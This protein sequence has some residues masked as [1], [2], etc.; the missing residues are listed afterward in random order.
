MNAT[1]KFD[2]LTLEQLGLLPKFNDI[3]DH[4]LNGPPGILVFSGAAGSGKDTVLQAT[5]YEAYQR[6]YPIRVIGDFRSFW[7]LPEEW[8]Q[9][10]CAYDLE[11]WQSAIGKIPVTRRH[12]ILVDQFNYFS[13]KSIFESV[14]RGHTVFLLWS[15]SFVGADVAYEL[16]AG[17]GMTNHETFAYF[18]AI[19]SQMLLNKICSVCAQKTTLTGEDVH[20]IDPD[21]T[22]SLEV[23]Q[24]VG[25]EQC[26]QQGIKGRTAIHEILIITDEVRSILVDYL[27]HGLIRALPDAGHITMQAA[28]REC[29]KNGLVGIRTYKQTVLFNPML[30]YQILL[31][32][33]K[34][35][36]TL[37]TQRMRQELEYARR[38]Q[39]SMLPERNIDHERLEI[40]GKMVTASEVG[41][42]YYD[43]IALDNQ[44]YCVAIGDA[45]GHGVA[46][47]LLV[48]MI[49]A[50]LINSLEF[51]Q[52]Q[53][54]IE[55]LLQKLNRALKKS[56]LEKGLGMCL[57]LSVFDLNSLNAQISMGVE[58]GS[59]GMPHPYHFDSQKRRLA[60]IEM[61]GPPLGFLSQ[62]KVQTRNVLLQP[63]D[64][65]I[66]LSDGFSER[67][68]HR[69]EIWDDDALEAALLQIC[70]EESQ[71]AQ[72]ADRLF[73]A[74]DAFA[75]SCPNNDDMTVV[76]IRLKNK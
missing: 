3:M 15:S 49:K 21:L 13:H 2:I 23:W 10:I 1:E 5:A 62:I 41:G 76:I 72:I 64:A 60:P 43:F 19:V 33:E 52:Q 67:M 11:A 51:Y 25:C 29:I 66:F 37:E 12:I 17:Q 44:R 42:D 40:V 34:T 32:K 48:G 75:G 39:L 38:I 31:E 73:A 70:C 27:D 54:A 14:R 28:A 50:A 61:S 9:T 26:Q 7:N 30:R 6:G 22:G 36:K 8:Q 47:G 58:L 59:S 20:I 68:N 69:R 65:L 74:C 16:R 57:A 71:A 24:E 56:T 63:G 46:A 18:S 35:I 53:V 55:D 45:T 4:V